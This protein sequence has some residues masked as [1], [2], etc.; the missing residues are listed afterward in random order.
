M[1]QRTIQRPRNSRELRLNVHQRERHFNSEYLHTQLR[2]WTPTYSSCIWASAI[3]TPQYLLQEH[4]KTRIGGLR[5]PLSPQPG[6]SG[7]YLKVM[8]TLL[9]RER[10]IIAEVRASHPRQLQDSFP[11][12]HL[13]RVLVAAAPSHTHVSG[14]ALQGAALT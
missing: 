3:L 10:M 8:A 14:L 6:R 1:R 4:K 5:S 13:P 2:A 11:R 7:L 9:L 12:V